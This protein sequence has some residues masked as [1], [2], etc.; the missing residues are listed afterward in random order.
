MS[1]TVLQFDSS[2]RGEQTSSTRHCAR[3]VATLIRFALKTK[4]RPRGAS[5]PLELASETRT[6]G[7]SCPWNLST[8]PTRT[9]GRHAR[10]ERAHLGVVGGDDEDVL[11]SE[12]PRPP[13]GVRVRR[14]EHSLDRGRD[15]ARLLPRELPVAGVLD[16][17]QE[18]PVPCRDAPP[19]RHLGHVEP[20]RV[21]G[22]GRERRELRPQPPRLGEEDPAIGRH[23][24]LVVEEVLEHRRLGDLGLRALHDLRELVGVAEEDEVARG[25]PDRDDVGERDLAGLVH[26]ER[27]AEAREVLAREERGGAG[28]ELELGV[29]ELLPPVARVHAIALEPGI[30]EA[31]GRLPQ[32][33]S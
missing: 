28:D 15:G 11:D 25:V 27:V 12:R 1:A 9:P 23:R 26:D 6:T 21:V 33:A 19:P 20:A 16:L 18:K 4:P 32:T 14:P 22:V 13:V 17:A 3:E 5:S 7:A 29:E 30:L 24:R 31:G 2:S 10:A 8:V